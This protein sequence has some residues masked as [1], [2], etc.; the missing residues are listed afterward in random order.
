MIVDVT[1]KTRRALLADEAIGE[2]EKILRSLTWFFGDALALVDFEGEKEVLR[3]IAINNHF[4]GGLVRED[5]ERTRAACDRWDALTGLVSHHHRDHGELFFKSHDGSVEIHLSFDEESLSRRA[6]ELRFSNLLSI[7]WEGSQKGNGLAEIFL[8]VMDRV[9]DNALFD[10]GFCCASDQYDKKN[11]DRSGG[12]V[13]AVGLDVSKCL[14]GFYWGNYFGPYLCDVIGREIL[15][16]VP[17]CGSLELRSGILVVNDLPPDQWSEEAFLENEKLAI[18]HA[19][20]RLFFEKGK[21]PE[22]ALFTC[23]GEGA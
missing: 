10:Y 11:I 16:N 12:G 21:E 22:G 9:F 14:P 3:E 6:G 8:S 20:P 23:P 17:G 1:A 5:V 2:V 4:L 19:G 7:N 18:A 13:R 15:V